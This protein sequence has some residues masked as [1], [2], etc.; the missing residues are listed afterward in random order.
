M[1]IVI[2]GA[3][4][5]IGSAL[6]P[7]LRSYGHDVIALVRREAQGPHE[8]SWDPRAGIIDADL[9]SSADAVVNLAGASIGDKRLTSSYKQLVLNS[10]FDSTRTIAEAIAKAAKPPAL[11]QGSSMGYYGDAGSSPLPETAAAG[12]GF[13]AD[14]CVQWEAAAQPAR[15]AGSRVV[16]LRT[17]LVLASHGG[18]AARLLPLLKLG[19]F[20]GFGSGKAIQSWI[21]LEDHVRAV[22]HLLGAAPSE[23][24]SHSGATV[25]GTAN[26]IAPHPV[27]DAEIMAALAKA[28]GRPH[29]PKIP[30]AL[31]KLAVG[32]A[33]ED[34]LTSQPGVPETLRSSGFVWNHPTIFEAA[35]YVTGTSNEVS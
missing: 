23:A 20:G 14:V 35:R 27:S 32:E 12:S 28:M 16:N 11:M 13:L 25:N 10:R 30:A 31:I 1:R 7:L 17:G 34:L 21:T 22:A 5:L 29:G 9:V 24:D 6:T 8:S 26:L 18:F 3:S 19:L 15:D 2:S 33:A 4:G